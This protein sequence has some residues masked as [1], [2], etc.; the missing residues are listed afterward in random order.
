MELMNM[1]TEE[2]TVPDYSSAFDKILY[3]LSCIEKKLDTI[4]TPFTTKLDYAITPNA[5]VSVL[6]TLTKIRDLNPDRG[7]C[8]LVNDSVNE[9]YLSL[10]PNPANNTGIRLNANGGTFSF[11]R[12][13]ELPW[14]GEVW[15]I[16]AVAA[17]NVS[18]VEINITS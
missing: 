3:A 12:L 7:I 6:T 2:K 17:S 15:G 9:I 11:G 18:V 1:A 13:T 4:G 8:I 5:N 10:G 16:N 14:T